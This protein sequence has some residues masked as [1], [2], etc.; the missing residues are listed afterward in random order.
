[1][2]IDNLVKEG[3][4]LVKSSGRSVA[5]V[6]TELYPRLEG[7]NSYNYFRQKIGAAAKVN[8]KADKPKTGKKKKLE[9]KP[10]VL[11]AWDFEGKG[12]MMGINEYCHR[13]NLPYEHVQQYKLITHTGT[14][15]YNTLFKEVTK[16]FEIV[17]VEAI[18]NTLKKWV[19][20]MEIAYPLDKKCGKWFDRLVYTDA[21]IGMD[22]DKDG[23]A[24]YPTTWN[25]KTQLSRAVS[26]ALELIANKSGNE[27][28]IDELGDFMDGYNGLT[29]RGGHT[30]PQN[31]SNEE[32]FDT[33]VAFKMLLIDT[34]VSHYDVV[35]VNNICNDNHAGSFGYLVNST[36]KSL[37]AGKYG[38]RVVVNNHRAFI[39]HYIVGRHAFVITHGKDSK[40]LKFGFKPH[41]DAKQI[42]KIDAYL[43]YNKIYGKA[44]FIEFSKG[45][46]HQMLLDYCTSDDFDYFNFPAFAPASEWVQTNFKKSRSGF[47]I[48]NVKY[49]ERVKNIIPKFFE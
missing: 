33:G 13:Y 32:A 20:P 11:S 14:P 28:Y 44:D 43:K 34:L 18:E 16:A 3:V 2:M 41:L 46:S 19:I 35:H 17:S 26:M 36:V 8:V 21:H 40:A 15:Y 42:E 27:V 31:M 29:V 47:V 4:E 5:S 24:M 39:N 45:D 25:K 12:K 6:A 30:L 9:P 48:E 23:I 38:E 49:D 22:T 7:A 1:M 37:C 10:F